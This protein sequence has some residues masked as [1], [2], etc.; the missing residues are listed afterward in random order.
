VTCV[1]HS[2]G[3]CQPNSPDRPE[4]IKCFAVLPSTRW[5]QIVSSNPRAPSAA[6]HMAQIFIRNFALPN[7]QIYDRVY[8]TRFGQST[9]ANQ[10]RPYRSKNL[11]PPLIN[12]VRT[13]VG[14]PLTGTSAEDCVDVSTYNSLMSASNAQND[15]YLKVLTI[16]EELHRQVTK[17]HGDATAATLTTEE[18]HFQ[19]TKYRAEAETAQRLLSDAQTE[20]TEL[21]IALDHAYNEVAK[22]TGERDELLWELRG[23]PDDN[24][25]MHDSS[26]R[27]PVP[28]EHSAAAPPLPLPRT[29]ATPRAQRSTAAPT[30]TT[31]RSPAARRGHTVHSVVGSPRARTIAR[32]ADGSPAA[33][34]AVRSPALSPAAARTLNTPVSSPLRG[35]ASIGTEQITGWEW[36]SSQMSQGTID[37]IMMPLNPSPSPSPPPFDPAH[38]ITAAKDILTL[39]SRLDQLASVT[40]VADLPRSSWSHALSELNLDPTLAHIII[41]KWESIAQCS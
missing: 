36:H 27:I 17:S 19:L 39:W 9:S 4:F 26:G 34:S 21:N 2:K 37:A 20:L 25:S 23:I 15:E 28:F 35:A 16:N 13:F 7:K 41:T 6:D 32:S 12:G 29:P 40:R 1:F 3:A 10:P 38:Y 24:S 11:I 22:L 30:A 31:P 18:L 8:A 14:R 33:R 5:E